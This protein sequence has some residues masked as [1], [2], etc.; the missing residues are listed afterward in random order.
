[1]ENGSTGVISSDRYSPAIGDG[2]DLYGSEGAIHF[3]T[4]TIKYCFFNELLVRRI[5]NRL[6]KNVIYK[7]FSEISI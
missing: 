1:M 4:E 3:A 7:T 2:T 5:H 6:N